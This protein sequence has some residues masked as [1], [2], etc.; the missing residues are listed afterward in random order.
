[1]SKLEMHER[2]TFTVLMILGI[3]FATLVAVVLASQYLTLQTLTCFQPCG[4]NGVDPSVCV[5]NL[6]NMRWQIYGWFL[7]GTY[8][9]VAI[10]GRGSFFFY[11]YLHKML[12][13]PSEQTP[14][15]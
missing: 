1:M 10:L 2:V 15:Q 11:L 12:D 14:T 6:L 9:I 4:V 5:T 7:I 13:K 3:L 8:I